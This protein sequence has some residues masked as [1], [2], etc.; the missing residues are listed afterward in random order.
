[1]P[2]M[3]QQ[4]AEAAPFPPVFTALSER[5]PHDIL[6]MEGLASL[7]HCH[8]ESIR[9]ALKN[10][11]L[12]APFPIPGHGSAWFVED[13]LQHWK[14]HRIHP[15]PENQPENPPKPAT[16]QRRRKITTVASRHNKV[17]RIRDWTYGKK[18]A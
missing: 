5:H 14:Q 4:S 7:L 17:S 6:T 15:L 12:P 18:D 16:H 8:I 9:R 2:D 13:I 3:S 10:G 1:M 11:D